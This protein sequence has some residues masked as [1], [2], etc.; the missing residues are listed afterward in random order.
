MIEVQEAAAAYVDRCFASTLDLRRH[1]SKQRG[2]KGSIL[3][4]E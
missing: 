4:Y 1:V 3:K 2:R